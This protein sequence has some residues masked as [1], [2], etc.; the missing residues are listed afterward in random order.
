[1]ILSLS[2]YITGMMLFLGLKKSIVIQNRRPN[3][4][5]LESLS[6]TITIVI[7][8]LYFKE[9]II[10]Q[11]PR[12][13]VTPIIGITSIITCLLVATRISFVFMYLSQKPT[14]H[15]ILS[16]WTISNYFWNDHKQLKV[17]NLIILICGCCFLSI[18]NNVAYFGSPSIW[19]NINDV[20]VKDENALRFSQVVSYVTNFILFLF[21]VQIIVNKIYDKIEM[22]LELVLYVITLTVSTVT[23]LAYFQS[24]NEWVIV[25]VSFITLFYSLYFPVLVHIIHERKKLLKTSKNSLVDSKILQLCKDFFCEENAIFLQQ[26]ELYRQN[27]V[28][29]TEIKRIFI[30]Q[31][32]IYELN[33][34]FDVRNAVLIATDEVSQQNALRDVFEE[35][36]LI[37]RDNILP[38]K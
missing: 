2:F 1:M 7:D 33:L 25:A 30:E 15:K 14:N 38:F 27:I 31:G 22:A 11:I 8:I 28:S 35:V 5:I 29:F 34:N 6:I 23:L 3:L 19:S 13:I 24:L 18:V 36:K 10:R 21:A 9:E 20:T 12:Y 37:I 16:M 32:S 26:Y 4:V 17:K